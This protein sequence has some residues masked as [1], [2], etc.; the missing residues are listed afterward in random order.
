MASIQFL[1]LEPVLQMFTN[2]GIETWGLF[3]GKQFLSAGDGAD[4]LRQYLNAVAPYGSQAIYTLKVYTG[5]PDPDEITDK[6]QANGSFNFKLT[7][8][9]VGAPAKVGGYGMG[10]LDPITAK[11]HELVA[12]KVGD[13]IEDI[14]NPK[15][16]KQ[17]IGDVIMGYL[18]DPDALASVIGAV[19][20]LLNRGQVPAQLGQVAG[21]GATAAQ[22]GDRVHRLAGALDRLERVDPQ[23]VEH[24][25]KL[26]DIGE[27]DPDIYKI[28]IK[29][30]NSF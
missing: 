18:E 3:Q 5:N 10:S 15:P 19:G 29:K 9:Q 14:L 21:L 26:A 12:A 23:L 2:R 27:Q 30:L 20:K 4:G 28:L 8:G 17:D 16:E 11:L 6:T 13:A 22:T 1:G 25:E 7:E 24:L